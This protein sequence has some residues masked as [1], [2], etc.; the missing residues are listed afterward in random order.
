MIDKQNCR[1]IGT[2]TKVHGVG[3]EVV[4]RMQPGFYSDEI[5]TG[6]LF[7]ELDGGLVPFRVTGLRD[8]GDNSLLVELK[9]ISRENE[10][11]RLVDCEVWVSVDDLVEGEAVAPAGAVIGYKVVDEQYGYLGEVIDIDDP[12]RNPLFVIEKGGKEILVP[13][14]DEFIVSIDDDAREITLRTPE[15]LID[16]ND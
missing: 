6:F 4:V 13:V 8:R 14:A 1:Q 15:G 12:E 2:I 9:G 3:G 5:E 16:L 7:L 10:A 11:K